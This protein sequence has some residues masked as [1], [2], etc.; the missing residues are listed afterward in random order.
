MCVSWLYKIS[1]LPQQCLLLDEPQ[2]PGSFFHN[3]TFQKSSDAVVS[4]L[5]RHAAAITF[6]LCA[7]P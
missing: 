2:S 6:S 3:V 5:C 7:D 1:L 4:L